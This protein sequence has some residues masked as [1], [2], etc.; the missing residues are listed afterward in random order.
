MLLSDDKISHLSHVIQSYLKKG[1]GARLKGDEVSALKVIKKVLIA[2]LAQEEEVGHIVRARLASYSR[3]IPEGS[4][5]W[6]VLYRKFFE[7]ETRK[8]AKP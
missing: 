4:Q 2:E 7:E 5:E 1:K 8:R 6:E 3:P